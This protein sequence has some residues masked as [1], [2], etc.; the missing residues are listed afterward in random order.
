[1]SIAETQALLEP[2]L[3]TQLPDAEDVHIEALETA[4]LGH[5]AETLLFTA[6]WRSSEGQH[7]RDVVLRSRPEGN[8]L[9]PPYDLGRQFD[10]LR[11]LE[12]T[13][14]RTPRALWREATGDVLGRDFYVM[15][16]VEGDV[17]EMRVPREIVSDPVRVRRMTEEIVDQIAAIHL[18]DL[19]ASGLTSVADGHDFFDREML[20]WTSEIRRLQRAPLPALERLADAVRE[21]QPEPSPHITLVHGDP[22]P[23]NFA[24]V[25]S[26]VSAVFDWELATIGDPL[27]DIGWAE[28]LW[29]A[30]VGLP[31]LPGALTIEEFIERYQ[32]LTEISIQHREWYRAF[33]MFKTAVIMLSGSM[34]FDS[35]ESDDLRFAHMGPVVHWYTQQ[36]LAELGENSDLESGPVLPRRERLDAVKQAQESGSRSEP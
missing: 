6:V 4:Q 22:K 34:L 36:A 31:S 35:G 18:V 16:R 21:Q 30:P 11:G 33:Q 1:M 28:L 3:A 24:F 2:W 15:E 26:T 5:S 12:G 27:A 10:I 29:A 32:Q 19:E 23:G 17:F 8:G 25:G 9:L 14:V 7:S 20:R 13:P